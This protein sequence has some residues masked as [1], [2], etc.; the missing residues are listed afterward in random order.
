MSLKFS[1]PYHKKIIDISIPSKNFAG[2]VAP[3]KTNPITDFPQA[4]NNALDNPIDS[5]PLNAFLKKGNQVVIIVSDITRY[6][7]ADLFLPHLISRINKNGIQDKEITIIFSL[8]IHRPMTPE[9]QKRIVSAEIADRI[10]LENHNSNDINKLISLGKTKRGTPVVINQRVA[11][12]DKIIVTG[13]IGLHYLAGFGGGRKSIIP[14]VSSFEG[15]V[16]NHLL[17]LDS[18]KTGR[19]PRARTGILGG[20]P[21]HEDMMEACTLLPPIF[22]FNTILSPNYDIVNFLAGNW[23]TAFYT[24]CDYIKKIFIIPISHPADLV[25]VSCGGFPK[26]INFIQS[27]KTLDY[28]MNALKPGGV[29][30]LIAS[31]QEGLGHPDFFGWFRFQDLKEMES[32]LRKNF[33]INGQTAYATLLKTQ[34]AKVFLLSDLPD[35]V[36]DAMSMTPVHSME[37]ALPKAY[38]LLGDN[39]STYVI[40]YGAAVLPWVE[41]HG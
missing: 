11:E 8:G 40:P 37:E 15:C 2:I 22:L 7:G 28:A 39:P 20:N 21:I 9:E 18:E 13:T 6:T 41:G 34:S 32:E 25:I 3:R 26:D 23:E 5:P 12:A 16:A 27:H 29:M 33:Q 19:H 4:V 24:G 17:V 14:G 35:S 36:A 30:I 1:L 10:R 38:H 31:C